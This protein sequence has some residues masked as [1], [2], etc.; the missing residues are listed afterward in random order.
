[1]LL[2]VATIEVLNKLKRKTHYPRNVPLCEKILEKP[3]YQCSLTDVYY[4]QK[5]I[6]VTRIFSQN[7]GIWRYARI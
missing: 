5:Y 6:R 1:M 3:R 7:A 4:V 2:K